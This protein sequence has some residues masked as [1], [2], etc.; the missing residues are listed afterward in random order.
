MRRC[1]GVLMVLTLLLS[2]GATAN[3]ASQTWVSGNSGNWSDTANWG[4][5]QV[6]AGTDTATINNGTASVT[7]TQGCGIVL[8]GNGLATDVAVLNISADLTVSK[9][10]TE[11]FGVSRIAGATGT[12][13][14]TAGTVRVFH[15]SAATGEF[16][17]A[18][19]A[20]ALGAYNLS[21]GVLDVQ[22]LNK[23]AKD[24]NVAFNATGGTLVVRNMINKFG[25]ISENASYGF[26]QGQAKLEVGAI[27]TV[28]AI[29]FGNSTNAMDYTVGTGGILNIDVASASSFDSI[30]QYGTLA[31]TLGA[32]L[33][34]DLL[35]GYVPDVGTT[36][37]VWTFSNKAMAGS[38]TF[39]GI[40]NGW[41]AGWV[42]TNADGSLDTLRLTVVPE[43]ATI[44]LLGLGLIA[45]RRNKK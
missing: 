42:D 36:F 16:R 9:G 5:A 10:T 8:M 45:L 22:V 20:G 28:G 32:T 23:G 41:A 2:F 25:L 33:G 40:T 3:A 44:A 24:R 14:Q 11:L 26:N 39:A 30:T 13:N 31:N 17:L 37:D 35:N 18:N 27:D 4:G 7:T 6:P 29:A 21:G 19:V 12:V 43:P 15:P 34:I 38:G 1:L